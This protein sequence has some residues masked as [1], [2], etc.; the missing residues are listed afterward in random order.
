MSNAGYDAT[1][2]AVSESI[3]KTTVMMFLSVI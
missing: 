1:R 2:K 3:K